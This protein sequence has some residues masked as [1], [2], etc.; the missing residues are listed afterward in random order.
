M[1]SKQLIALCLSII[2]AEVV[3]CFSSA[4]T[5]T[6][7]AYQLPSDGG[8]AHTDLASTIDDL[9]QTVPF[10]TSQEFIWVISGTVEWI[11]RGC[12]LPA[13]H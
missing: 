6:L 2:A 3:V 4:A 12:V 8:E 5:S 13:T 1:K 9:A 7:P 11:D 10:A